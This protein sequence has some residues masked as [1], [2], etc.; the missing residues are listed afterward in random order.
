MRQKLTELKG[1]IY[2]C[3]MTVG[4]FNT[5]LTKMGRTTRQNINKETEDIINTITQL[6]LT[7]V[8]RT[9]HTSTTAYSI[10]SSAHRTFS[11]I[12]YMLKPQNESQ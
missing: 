6:D 8:Y 9:V 5:S 12:D 1:E 2:M 11:S 10:F 7:D 4:D 3:T